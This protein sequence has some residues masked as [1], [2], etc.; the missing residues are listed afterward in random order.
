MK[1]LKQVL[2]AVDYLHSLDIVYVSLEPDSIIID[3][4]DN[5]RLTDYGWSKVISIEMNNRKGYR[6][7]STGVYINSY[8][9]PE[10]IVKNEKK[11]KCKSKKRKCKK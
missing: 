10:L 6:D 3:E 8:T 4:N 1:Y 2:I 7:K 5:V 9:P 11:N